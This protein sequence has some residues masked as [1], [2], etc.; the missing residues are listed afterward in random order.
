MLD[1]HTYVHMVQQDTYI[2]DIQDLEPEEIAEQM[3][4]RKKQVR[5]R[6]M[7]KIRREAE[8]QAEKV[9]RLKRELHIAHKR[10]RTEDGVLGIV[11][12]NWENWGTGF[13]VKR[14]GITKEE[15][16]T[17]SLWIKVEPPPTSPLTYPPS[18]TSSSRFHSIDPNDFV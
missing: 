13:R 2:Y 11:W 10:S 7:R 3:R 1:D 12:W 18:Q 15:P 14:L 16:S 9:K 17:P 6:R 8:I 5:E 4:I